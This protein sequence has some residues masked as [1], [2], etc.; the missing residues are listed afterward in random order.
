MT[1]ELIQTAEKAAISIRV[2]ATNFT[3]AY[4]S[5]YSERKQDHIWKRPA[6][7]VIK[8]NVDA[9]FQADFLS[10]AT[11]AIARDQRG[12]VIAA[13]TWYLP[14]VSTRA[15]MQLKL[16]QFVTVYI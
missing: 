7:D 14:Q 4:S 16:W 8:V 1:K 10:G 9:A 2:L 3:R 13:A 11:G 6:N 15:L 12:T 5:K